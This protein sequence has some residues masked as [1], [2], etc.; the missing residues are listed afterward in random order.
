LE[1]PG[2]YSTAIDSAGNVV[3]TGNFE[4]TVDFGNG[5]HVSASEFYY[6]FLAKL[7]P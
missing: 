4:G 1:I 7:T 6:V 5:P 3:I 2:A